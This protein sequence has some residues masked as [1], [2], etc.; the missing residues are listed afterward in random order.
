MNKR[1]KLEVMI[2]RAKIHVEEIMAKHDVAWN[3]QEV[4]EIE[5]EEDA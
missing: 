1:Q 2:M 5:E 4:Q 3:T